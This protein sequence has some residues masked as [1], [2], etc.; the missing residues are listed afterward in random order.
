MNI[1]N[2]EQFHNS[3]GSTKEY[4]VAQVQ[5][6]K[7][8]QI[9]EFR[10]SEECRQAKSK[11][12]RLTLVK[13]MRPKLIQWR[14]RTLNEFKDITRDLKNAPVVAILRRPKVDIQRCVAAIENGIRFIEIT[15]ESRCRIVSALD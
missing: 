9:K 11:Q 1:G 10:T 12:N 7:K 15:M 4:A 5:P 3:S 13:E 2:M 14:H 6:A 8:S